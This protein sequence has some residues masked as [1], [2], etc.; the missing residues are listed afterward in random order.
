MNRIDVGLFDFDWHHSI[1]FFIVSPDE[2]IYLRYGGRDAAS[3]DSYLDLDSFALALRAGLEEHERWLAGELP[4]RPRPPPF[5]ARELERLVL[6]APHEP[7]AAAHEKLAVPIVRQQYLEA[8]FAADHAGDLAVRHRGAR[9]ARRHTLRQ[10]LRL[11]LLASRGCGRFDS[12]VGKAQ[13]R[14]GRAIQRAEG[15]GGQAACGQQDRD[16]CRAIQDRRSLRSA[17][18]NANG[19]VERIRPAHLTSPAR[20]AE[21]TAHA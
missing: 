10:V 6:D 3:A 9:R 8:D 11:S 1:Y 19:V 4:A 13:F 21:S 2:Q 12:D 17:L 18:V 15:S 5:F 7:A 14:Q 20:M 16:P